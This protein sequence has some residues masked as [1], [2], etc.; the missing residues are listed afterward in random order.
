MIADL[1]NFFSLCMLSLSIICFCFPIVTINDEPVS[2]PFIR[3][4]VGPVILVFV[5]GLFVIIFPFIIVAFFWALVFDR[6]RIRVEP[7]KITW[8]R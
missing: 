7:F 4:I 2:N 1:G 5:L 8:R 3:A 6:D